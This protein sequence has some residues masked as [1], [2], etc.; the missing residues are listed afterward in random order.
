M[1]RAIC[2]HCRGDRGQL[3]SDKNRSRSMLSRQSRARR[4]WHSVCGIRARIHV[5]RQ[6]ESNRGLPRRALLLLLP[7]Y[8]L[9]LV[10]VLGF[11]SVRRRFAEWGVA[12]RVYGPAVLR[13]VTAGAALAGRGGGGTRPRPPPFRGGFLLFFAGEGEGGLVK[14]FIL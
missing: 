1:S 13:R 8:V 3:D 6:L 5:V 7:Q 12:P 14:K 2:L 4:E 9:R 10:T 11:Q